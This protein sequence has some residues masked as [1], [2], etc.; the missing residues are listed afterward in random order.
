MTNYIIPQII[1]YLNIDNLLRNNNR[2]CSSYGTGED[3]SIDKLLQKNFICVLGEPGTGKSRLIDEVKSHTKIALDCCLASELEAK[4]LR[5]DV[6]FCIIDALDEVEGNVF[7]STL[8][9]IR[10]FK[11]KHPKIKVLFTCRKH[12]ITS[13]AKIFASCKDLTYVELCRLSNHDVMKIVDKCSETTR[14]NVEKSPVL[15]RLL[16]VPRYLTFLLDYDEE[17]GSCT[18]INE[19]FEFIIGRSIQDAIAKYP[20]EIKNASLGILIQR[21]LEKVAF[22][23]EISRKDQISKDELYTILD[24]VKGNIAQMLLANFDLLFFESRILKNTNGILQFE[25]TELQE[26]L[27]AKE[28]CRQA[29]IES[30]LYDVAVHRNKYIYPNWYDVIPHIS[31]IVDKADSFIN[32]IKLIVSYESSIDTEA[33]T[34]LLRYIDLSLFSPQQKKELFSILFNHYLRVPTYIGWRSAILKLMQEC[35]FSNCINTLKITTKQFNKIVYANISTIL[36]GI[37]EENKLDKEIFDH[38]THQADRLMKTI[39]ED[40]K[41]AALNIYSAIKAQERLSRLS[42]EYSTFS[43]RIKEK[44]CEVTGYGKLENPKVV[45]CWLSSCYERNPYAINAVLR[46]ERPTTILYAYNEIVKVN[47]LSEFF[48]PMGALS[49]HFE[50]S[51]KNQFDIVW[52]LDQKSK[53]LIAEVITEYLKTD[54][55]G[56]HHD[57]Y[58]VLKEVLLEESTRDKLTKHFV[59]EWELSSILTHFEADLIDAELLQSIE[60]LLNK[61]KTRKN[62]VDMILCTLTNKIR[63]DDHKKAS[64]S[65]YIMRYSEIFNQWDHSSKIEG[66]RKEDNLS[67]TLAYQIISDS[68]K[69]K[70][71]KYNAAYRLTK[72]VEFIK[73]QDV[74]PLMEVIETFMDEVNLDDTKLMKKEKNQFC[75][76]TILAMIPYYSRAL[77]HLGCHSLLKKYRDIL[78]KTLPIA[79]CTV[80]NDVDE[81]RKIYKV[82]IGNLNEK[83]KKE[84]VEWWKGRKDDYLNIRPDEI[85]SCI[86]EYGIEA[87]AYKLEEFIKEYVN[88]QDNID[89]YN[90]CKALEL[91]SQGHLDWKIEDYKSL[92]KALRKD[93]VESVKMLCNAILI[94][95]YKDKE[96]ITWRIN[97]LK[98]HTIKSHKHESGHAY[99]LSIEE[100]E[101]TSQNPQ[102]FKCFMG[103]K[104]YESLDSQ[105]LEL[106]DFGLSL[107]SS[108]D[109]QEYAC[110]LLNQIYLFFINSENEFCIDE[111]RRKIE[112]SSAIWISLRVNSI[113]TSNE[114]LYLRRGKTS[115]NK[116]IKLY[117]KCIEES[118]LEIRNDGDLRRYFT[119]IY[120]EVQKE[121]QDQGI[122]SLV[123]QEVL[124]EDF[125]QRVLKNTII[126]KCCQMGLETFQVDREV[127]LQDN[128]RTDLLVRYGFCR[129]IMIEIKLLHNQEIQ[130]EEKR[131][132]YKNKFIKYAKATNACLSVFWVFKTRHDAYSYSRFHDLK[133]EYETLDNTLVL[134]TDCKCSSGYNTGL[135][136]RR[137]NRKEKESK[138]TKE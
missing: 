36:E 70:A 92:F 104:G 29:N 131:H 82:V 106:F 50:Y 56:S 57:I 84:L 51:L 25:N 47:K 22:I 136:K 35:Y 54:F 113:M 30:F 96:A 89:S 15:K 133:S 52:K 34:S 112:Q 88:N 108:V 61:A 1:T 6:E 94:E 83:E 76:S 55:C 100:A 4:P 93:D 10:D 135:P 97:Y 8:Q 28:L 87:L 40:K 134:L 53:I 79:C 73:E 27:A 85:M 81:I 121:I 111:L 24:G 3:L 67:L 114:M 132:R 48:N 16:T 128:K 49:V 12:Y 39:D 119:Y 117:N 60:E 44:Y 26:Y 66:K 20:I 5:T 102:M 11:E 137:R 46:I 9:S 62:Y 130:N 99:A 127:A 19:L 18:N 80:S 123:N 41:I 69:T 38:W 118:H 31:Y 65:E 120:S 37:S 17:R 115:I 13:F 68:R 23:M 129:P 63:N 126:S 98:E 103:I 21:V 109:M 90:A 74:K 59:K 91:I 95:K 45:D 32:I 14:D 86:T 72:D 58:C 122:Y 71:E 64:V 78:T 110:Y 105:M 101:M 107:F 124:Q 43:A 77:Y 33:F 2:N 138:S 7:F 125:I 116:A 42:K 75:I